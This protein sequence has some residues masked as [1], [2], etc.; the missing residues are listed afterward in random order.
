MKRSFLAMLAALLLAACAAASLAQS[1]AAR[2]LAIPSKGVLFGVFVNAHGGTDTNDQL[3]DLEARIGRRAK[4]SL[5]FRGFRTDFPGAQEADDV[6]H[7]RIPIESWNCGDSDANVAAGKDDATIK[8]RADALRAFGHP[9]FVRYM[10]E[11]NLP[12]R[13]NGRA[14]CWDPRTDLPDHHFS[15]Q[16]FVAAWNHIHQI[17]VNEGATNVIWL[18]CPSNGRYD[19][20]PYY[21]G[22]ATV[23]WVGFDAYRH[24]RI[25]LGQLYRRMYGLES[26]LGK[27]IMIGETAAQPAVQ[28]DTFANLPNVLRTEFPL[29]KGVVY[30]DA[31]GNVGGWT[32]DDL[33]A[34]AK[35]A[36]DPY[37]AGN[38]N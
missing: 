18:W 11:M 26:R 33:S 1:G 10:W 3:K 23:D 28:D 6:A 20:M 9:I 19:P 4:L 38:R 32:I 21:P 12:S 2:D 36:N 7:G 8:T 15:T 24:G 31:P 22:S 14:Q 27:P 34:F 17:F 16:A 25:P 30:F 13:A 5:H 29:I 37:L 35:M